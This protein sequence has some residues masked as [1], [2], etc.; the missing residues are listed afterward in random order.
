MR[1]IPVLTVLAVLIAAFPAEAKS[2]PPGMAGSAAGLATAPIYGLPKNFLFDTGE[3]RARFKQAAVESLEQ[4]P[5]PLTVPE[6]AAVEA[7]YLTRQIADHPDDAAL[8]NQRCF[9]RG[10]IKHDLDLALADCD[11]ALTLKPGTL[12]FLDRRALV[13]YLQGNYREALEAY[14]AI[15]KRDP[16]Y[17]ASLLLRGYAR[18]ALGDAAGKDADIA[19]AKAS[20]PGI[21]STFIRLGIITPP[22]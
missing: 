20:N 15:L 1:S 4:N 6:R 2:G 14:N 9:M 12:A 22:G 11:H 7:A 17:A 3:D 16:G 18:G 21:A 19:A 10:L 5:P 8:F 13:L